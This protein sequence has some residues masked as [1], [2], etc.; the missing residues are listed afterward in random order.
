MKIYGKRAAVYSWP[1]QRLRAARIR[2]RETHNGIEGLAVEP[3]TVVIHQVP[4]G[5]ELAIRGAAGE[6]REMFAVGG[7]AFDGVTAV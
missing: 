5:F 1:L 3:M 4:N 6:C 2:Q 7:E